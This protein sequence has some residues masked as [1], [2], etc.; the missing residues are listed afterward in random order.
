MQRSEGLKE[1]KESEVLGLF[2]GYFLHT[3]K[4]TRAPIAIAKTE[5]QKSSWGINWH[6]L[7]VEFPRRKDQ[8]KKRRKEE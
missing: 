1:K 7:Q 6:T 2:L 3:C 8:Y 5:L 4:K